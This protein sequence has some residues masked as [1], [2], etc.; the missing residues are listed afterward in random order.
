MTKE[1]LI[2]LLELLVKENQIWFFIG[3]LISSDNSLETKLFNLNFSKQLIQIV[4]ETNIE[5]TIKDK[6]KNHLKNTVD[7]LRKEV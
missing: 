6:I 1:K 2:A 7:V 5:K 4:D 3:N